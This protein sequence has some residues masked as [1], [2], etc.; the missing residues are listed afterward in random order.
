M[1]PNH[2]KQ[3][4]K[5]PSKTS[6]RLIIDASIA[7]ASGGKSAVHPTSK[8]CRDFLLAT[9]KVCHQAVLTPE[10]QEE[11]DRHQSSFARLWR[12]SMVA[13]RKLYIADVSPNDRLRDKIIRAAAIAKHREAMLKDTHLIEAAIA[14]DRIIVSL[15][16]TVRV[17]FKVASQRVGELRVI[18]WANPDQP[19]ERCV[20]WLE[21]GAKTERRRQLGF[22][23]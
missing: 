23:E 20:I 17:L 15:D 21:A 5:M 1:L 4:I 19:E 8:R 14:T 11:W 10:L 7:H 13:R 2:S 12:Q 22:I 6:K 18:M 3:S 9:L 16:E